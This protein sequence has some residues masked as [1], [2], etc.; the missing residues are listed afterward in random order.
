MKITLLQAK[1]VA[2]KLNLN[3][4]VI[5]IR[6][7]RDAMLIELEHGKKYG[8]TTNVTNDN[9]LLTG[10]IAVAHLIEYPDYYKRLNK[11]EIKAEKYWQKRDKPNV[12]F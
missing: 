11:M 2:T 8:S 4:N 6:V 10:K 9:L 1:Q 7:F 5:P 12:I 3:L